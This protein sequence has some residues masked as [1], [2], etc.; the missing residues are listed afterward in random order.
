MR[1]CLQQYMEFG[2]G[3]WN[4]N[5]NR[6]MNEYATRLAYHEFPKIRPM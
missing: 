1:R 6:A 5:A 3:F 4:G 2:Y